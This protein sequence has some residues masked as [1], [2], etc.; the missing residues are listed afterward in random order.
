MVEKTSSWKNF[1]I[2]VTSR[3]YSELNKFLL[4]LGL[5]TKSIGKHGGKDLFE[6]LVA[7]VV[8]E[9]ELISFAKD[10]E[11]DFSFSFISPEAARVSFG[12]GIPHIICSDSPHAWAPCRLAV[13]LCKLLFSPFPIS[14]ER[15]T[16]YALNPKQVQ[17]YHALDPWAWLK[18]F[19]IKVSPKINGKVIIRLEESFASYF[20]QGLGVSSVLNQLLDGIHEIGDFEITLV[21]RYD[22]QRKWAQKEFASKAIVPNDA[23]DGVEEISEADLL[24]GG[25]ATMT[26]EAALLGVPNISYFPSA[27]LDV[28]SRFYFPRRLS[29]EASNPKDLVKRTLSLLKKIEKEKPLFVFRA[30]QETASFEDPVDF[31]FEQLRMLK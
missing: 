16:Q 4:H 18:N 30:N 24:I 3:D 21:P 25:G 11:F 9:N 15:W 1:E 27:E 8:R 2:I 19:K 10:N 23:I 5:K 28:F 14:K 7:S 6:K 20:R 26:Q 17:R 29:I 12:L 31:I 13:P 22:E